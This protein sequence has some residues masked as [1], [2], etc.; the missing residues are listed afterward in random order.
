MYTMA[1]QQ[2]GYSVSTLMPS[3]LGNRRL[4][5]EEIPY[6]LPCNGQDL[7]I[8][9]HSLYAR[10]KDVCALNISQSILTI[11]FLR[12]IEVE[13]CRKKQLPT[14]EGS[15]QL[16]SNILPSKAAPLPSSMFSD[17]EMEQTFFSLDWRLHSLSH[18]GVQHCPF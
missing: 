9:R 2:R 17:G 18:H 1:C 16:G 8:P 15:I 13:A 11:P 7:F 6:L 14:M 10:F 3:A 5:I 4:G 12:R